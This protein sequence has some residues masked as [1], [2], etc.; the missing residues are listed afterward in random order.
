VHAERRYRQEA[1]GGEGHSGGMV[2]SRDEL[3]MEVADE[4]RLNRMGEDDEDDSDEED[5]NDDA[6]DAATLPMLR[7]LLLPWK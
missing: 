1:E 4:F 2:Q 7:H 6:G 3:L 5:D